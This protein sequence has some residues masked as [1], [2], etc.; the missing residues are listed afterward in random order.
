M[1][2]TTPFTKFVSF[3]IETTGLD[4]ETCQTIEIGAVIDDWLTPLADPPTFHVYIKRDHYSGQPYALSM[5][6]TIFRRIATEE[7]GYRYLYS[8]DVGTAFKTWVELNH[9]CLYRDPSCMDLSYDRFN[10]AGKNFAMFDDR[11]LR[12]LPEFG[13]FFRYRHRVIDPAILFWDPLTDDK[14]PDTKTCM[15]RAGLSGE[16]A[17]NALDDAKIVVKLIHIGVGRRVSA[18]GLA[19]VMRERGLDVPDFITDQLPRNNK[20]KSK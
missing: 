13:K 5:H 2:D 16:V 4:P 11:F 8:K 12:K 3:D 18:T 17:H 7:E 6:S 1:S 19:V 9:A 20:Y 15:E 10:V 14:L